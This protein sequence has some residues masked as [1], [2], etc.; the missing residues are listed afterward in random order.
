M[1][2]LPLIFYL[3]SV[4]DNRNF[5]CADLASRNILQYQARLYVSWFSSCVVLLRVS[6]NPASISTELVSA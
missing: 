6:Q 1:A 5:D 2:N 4:D 3:L